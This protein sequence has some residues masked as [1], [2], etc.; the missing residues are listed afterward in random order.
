MLESIFCKIILSFCNTSCY[1][2]KLKEKWTFSKLQVFFQSREK[3]PMEKQPEVP[4]D[5][6]K[7]GS[8]CSRR[9]WEYKSVLVSQT[10]FHLSGFRMESIFIVLLQK[11]FFQTYVLIKSRFSGFASVFI[12]NI[13][14]Q[15]SL[16]CKWWC[17]WGQFQH[18]CETPSSWRSTDSKIVWQVWPILPQT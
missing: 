15:K 1:W 14:N 16:L 5:N 3:A 18:F 2:T 11:L 7:L 9:D 4:R 8:F 17:K 13:D 10:V 12:K 6:L